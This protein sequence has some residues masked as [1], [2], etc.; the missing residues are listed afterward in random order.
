[1]K[2]NLFKVRKKT[3][4]R[5]LIE[6]EKYKNPFLLF[7]K[8]HRKLLLFSIFSLSLCLILASVGIAFSAF[9]TSKDFDISYLN[10]T[11]DKITTDN[12]PNIKDEDVKEELLGEVARSMGV[13]ILV[14]TTMTKN[15]D[16]IYYFSDFSSIIV[17]ANGKIHRVSSVNGDYGVDSAG[18]IKTGAKSIYVKANNKTLQDGTVITYYSDGTAKLEHNN[19]TIFVRDSNNIKLD[20]GVKYSNVIPSGVSILDSSVKSDS[21]TM[22]TYTDNAKYI[23][24]GNKKY[25][26]NPKADASNTD[27]NISYDKNNSFGVFNE[28]KLED[29]NNITYFDNGTAIITKADGRTIFVKKSG[30]IVVR[31]NKIYE[32]ITNNYGYSKGNVTTSDKKKITYFDNGAAIIEYSD[33]KKTYVEDIDEIL[34]DQNKN[35]IGKP[36]EYAEKS[37]KKTKDG[38]DVINFDNGKS[39]VIKKD[40]TS[41]IIDTAKLIFDSKGNITSDNKK[42]NPKDDNK[43][44]E[45]KKTDNKKDDDKSEDTPE[46]PLE[47]MFVSDATYTYEDDRLKNTQHS[48]FIIKNSSIHKKKFRISIEEISNYS[49]YNASPLAANLVKFQ[50]TVGDSVV[51]PNFLNNQTWKDENN[52]VN[53]VI[54]DGSINPKSELTV[55]VKLYIDYE[56]LNNTHQDK[57][58]IGTIKVYVNS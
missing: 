23:V 27:S 56:I 18:N 16:V 38:Y 35:I 11:T 1:M 44:D 51:G 29:G 50:A 57:T 2:T 58:F 32:I 41:F 43:K 36:P 37:I 3:E 40:G 15:Q 17:S 7:F 9:R 47:G 20:A 14:K 10:K 24:D 48:N 53:Y 4:D 49:K 22:S 19:I 52:K 54:Y 31:N 55:D 5:I 12:N 28:K 45:D 8:R 42:N 25:I 13:V 21:I 34:Y 30:D 33:G 46:D 26:L 6:E 39:Q